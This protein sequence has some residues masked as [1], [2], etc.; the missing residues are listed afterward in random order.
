MSR[1]DNGKLLEVR[2]DYI[3]LSVTH[4]GR[5][6]KRN[7]VLYFN[8]PIALTSQ[9]TLEAARDLKFLTYTVTFWVGQG[10]PLP[11]VSSTSVQ[12]TGADK[13]SELSQV[14]IVALNLNLSLPSCSIIRIFVREGV[15]I[16]GGVAAGMCT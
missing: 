16:S 13:S 10:K 9:A 2:L 3:K 14:R 6:S 12:L 4:K 7:E 15:A 8:G 1:S 11:S 5:G